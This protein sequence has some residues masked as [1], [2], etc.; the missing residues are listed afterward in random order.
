MCLASTA[1]EPGY[2]DGNYMDCRLLQPNTL[3]YLE[4]TGEV[5]IGERGAYGGGLRRLHIASE[6]QLKLS[7]VPLTV[8]EASS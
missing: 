6:Y 5:I 3:L 1:S 2:Q 4:K 8:V 7:T